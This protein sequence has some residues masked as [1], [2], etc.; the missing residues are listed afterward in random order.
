M[1]RSCDPTPNTAD[2]RP[3]DGDYMTDRCTRCGDDITL[4]EWHPVA[5]VRDDDGT[6]QIYDFCC[7]ACRTAWQDE[8]DA[9]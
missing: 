2:D 4:E 3:T 9:D 8:R 7:E 6:V 1:R 5:T